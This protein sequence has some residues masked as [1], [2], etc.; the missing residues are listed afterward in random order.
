M[1]AGVSPSRGDPLEER[2]SGFVAPSAPDDADELDRRRQSRSGLRR[3]PAGCR[4]R[5]PG[6]RRRE[7][8]AGRRPRRDR[9][10]PARS[11]VGGPPADSLRGERARGPPRAEEARTAA[12]GPPPRAIDRPKDGEERQRR[13]CP[14]QSAHAAHARVSSTSVSPTSKTTARRSPSAVDR[15]RRRACRRQPGDGASGT[16]PARSA[17]ERRAGQLLR[18]DRRS[19]CRS[20]RRRAGRTG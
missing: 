1:A 16:G 9:G 5:R 19:A 10:P 3:P 7:R 6:S 13:A 11:R 15:A 4:R 14:S 12:D 18:L 8:R 20:A 17:A 2:G